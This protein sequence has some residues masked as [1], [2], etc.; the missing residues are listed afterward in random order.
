[1]GAFLLYRIKGINDLLTMVFKY[2]IIIILS[3]IRGGKYKLH[4]TANYE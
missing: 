2:I 3:A 4:C 1:M